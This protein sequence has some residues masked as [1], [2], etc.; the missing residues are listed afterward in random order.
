M[1]TVSKVVTLQNFFQ[2][3]KKKQTEKHQKW[4]INLDITKPYFFCQLSVFFSSCY[5]FLYFFH[6]LYYFVVQFFCRLSFQWRNFVKKDFFLA[7]DFF[8]ALV[9]EKFTIFFFKLKFFVFVRSLFFFRVDTCLLKLN[10]Y[11]FVSFLLIFFFVVVKD[12]F[13]NTF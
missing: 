3:P 6:S 12:I 10:V 1:P 9:P 4:D 7:T 11:P 13:K 2:S 8:F 5:S